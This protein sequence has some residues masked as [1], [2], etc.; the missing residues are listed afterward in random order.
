M[1]IDCEEFKSSVTMASLN[2]SDHVFML[3]FAV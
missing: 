3:T 2:T 1:T